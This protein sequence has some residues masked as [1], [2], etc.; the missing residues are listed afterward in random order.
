MEV[1]LETKKL[2]QNL[3]HLA[4]KWVLKMDVKWVWVW[5]WALHLKMGIAM[6]MDS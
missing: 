1:L 4:P 3:P 2:N 5:V 6:G